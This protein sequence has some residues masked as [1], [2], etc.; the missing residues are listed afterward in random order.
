MDALKEICALPENTAAWEK[1]GCTG[2]APTVI[3]AIAYAEPSLVFRLGGK[4]TLPPKSKP[5]IPPVA[6]DNRPAWLINI[7]EPE[8]REALGQ[9]TEAAAAAD[10][11]IRFSRRYA[12]NYSNGD[13]SILVAA[14]V[15]PAGCVTEAPPQD[16]RSTQDAEDVPELE[17]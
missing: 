1:S 2:R 12:F 17:R 13:P 4:I 16:L 5:V 8:G 14:V 3:H 6:D 11:C 15:E 9:L 10:R 7:N